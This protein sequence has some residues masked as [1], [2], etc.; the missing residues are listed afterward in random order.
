MVLTD[1][2]FMMTKTKHL[3]HSLLLNYYLLKDYLIFVD[4]LL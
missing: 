1:Y 2:A 4:K 3:Q